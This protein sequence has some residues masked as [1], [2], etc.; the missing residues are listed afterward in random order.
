MQNFLNALEYVSSWLNATVRNSS[1]ATQILFSRNVWTSY[2]FYSNLQIE[3]ETNVVLSFNQKSDFVCLNVSVQTCVIRN[4]KSSVNMCS[5][6]Y[7][8]SW[9]LRSTSVIV[10]CCYSAFAVNYWVYWDDCQ[11]WRLR[12]CVCLHADVCMRSCECVCGVFTQITCAA[13]LTVK[14][15]TRAAPATEPNALDLHI[16]ICRRTNI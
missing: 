15:S 13:A 9:F 7:C 11:C 16:Y 12:L 5:V 8:W 14:S 10:W 1:D 2:Y 3:L 6:S 4:I